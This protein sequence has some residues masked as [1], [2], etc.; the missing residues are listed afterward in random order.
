MKKSLKILLFLSIAIFTMT[1]LPVN[2][3]S[4]QTNETSD[5]KLLK[6]ITGSELQKVI[7]S[8]QGEK[9]VLINVWATWCA[10]CIK[11][12]PEIVKLQRNYPDNLKV[13]F[14][15]ADFPKQRD[16]A[17]EF[18]K[19][20]NVDWTTY[21]KTGKDQQFI[22]SLSGNWTGALPFTK[23][24]GLNGDLVA[25]WE[26]SASYEKFEHHVKTAINP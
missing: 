22:E 10:P 20:Q 13:I 11:E 19:E 7:D 25:S 9:A 4:A 16:A 26:Q 21:F 18:L 23:V 2:Y 3:M 17:L 24:I 5:D 12:F 15:S 8:Y 6:D 14:V 1:M